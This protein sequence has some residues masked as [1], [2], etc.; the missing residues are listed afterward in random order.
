MVLH[1]RGRS[2]AGFYRTEMPG[3]RNELNSAMQAVGGQ[4]F[5][6]YL[7]GPRQLPAGLSVELRNPHFGVT[8]QLRRLVND[9]RQDCRFDAE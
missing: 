8:T 3:F 1:F 5:S 4:V 6:P 9:A 7:R 2:S